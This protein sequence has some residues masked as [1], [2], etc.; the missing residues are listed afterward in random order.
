ML[1]AGNW[2]MNTDLAEGRELAIAV[3]NGATSRGDALG[4]VDL[5][6]CP[7]YVSLAP[8]HDALEG[9]AVALGAQNVHASDSGAFTGEVSAPML[10]SVGCTYVIVG[11]S[12]RREYYGET[13]EVVRAKLVQASAYD[14]V[15]ILC[16][17]E[18]KSDRD[19]G[20]AEAVVRRQLAGA[21]HGVDLDD[22]SDLVVAYEPVWAIGTGDTAT[23][24]QANAMHAFIRSELSEMYDDDTAAG[25]EVLYGGSMKPHNA[26]ELL[27]QPDVDGGLIGGAS[28]KAESFLAIADH[29]AALTEA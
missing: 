21:L 16:V 29:A 19:A 18:T 22:P 13:D 9:S 12:E 27:S 25:V 11:H 7:P 8:I 10:T 26:E 23:P 28:L 14:L 3:A 17:G 5:L 4:G 1:I 2:K 20:D 24:E 15:P 6:V